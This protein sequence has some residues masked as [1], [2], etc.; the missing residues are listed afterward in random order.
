MQSQDFVT[1]SL[2]PLFNFE[3]RR[4]DLTMSSFSY[5]RT[6]GADNNMPEL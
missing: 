6:P 5:A 1:F 3:W 2:K 4:G